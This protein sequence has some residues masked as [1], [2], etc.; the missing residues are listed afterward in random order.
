MKTPY[1]P[2]HS[3]S[4]WTPLLGQP[5]GCCP[6]CSRGAWAA[7]SRSQGPVTGAGL[8][9]PGSCG[10]QTGCWG[11]ELSDGM[12]RTSLTWAPEGKPGCSCCRPGGLC[13]ALLTGPRCLWPAARRAP[14]LGGQLL[15][16]SRT[17]TAPG[18][19]GWSLR[20]L[21]LW[22][23]WCDDPVTASSGPLLGA[24]ILLALRQAPPRQLSASP[25][26]L[27]ALPPLGRP[28]PQTRRSEVL[29][30]GLRGSLAM[31]VLAG[32]QTH[33]LPRWL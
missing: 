24:G 22:R 12:T 7:G 25:E 14:G 29:G 5:G 16:Q 28:R 23:P 10:Q 30:S 19:A 32:E 15:R 21:C 11:A 20:G 26:G 4:S 6:S 13:T 27:A 18:R 17:P 2:G 33:S 1:P 9:R 31:L 3:C 8:R